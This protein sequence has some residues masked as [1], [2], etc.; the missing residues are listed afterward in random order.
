MNGVIGFGRELLDTALA[1]EQREMMC[2][3][4]GSAEELLVLLNDI[5]DFSRLEASKLR[6]EAVPT[7]L[8]RLVED[9][10]KLVEPETRKL[11]LELRVLCDP[12]IPDSVLSDRHR[13]RQVLCNLLTNAVKF[14][15]EGSVTLALRLAATTEHPNRLRFEVTDTGMGVPA[16]RRDLLF[17]PFR[18][19]DG[20]HARKFGGS[21]LG[22]S[23]CTRLVELMG[24]KIEVQSEVGSGSEFWFELDLPATT[25]KPERASWEVDVPG[26][27]PAPLVSAQAPASPAAAPATSQSP[28]PS[29]SPTRGMRI[30]LAEDNLTN[31]KLIKHVLSKLGSEVTVADDGNQVVDAFL[32]NPGGWDLILMDCQMPEKDGFQATAEIRSREASGPRTPIIALT[33]NAMVGDRERC[34]AAGM[35]DYL[36]K[37]LLTEEL[38][39]VLARWS[40]PPS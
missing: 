4:V 33:A 20:S 39:A 36:T 32:G 21:G 35:D 15:R 14:T 1:P 10:A 5:L 9:V 16:E 27:T 34:L 11:N 3:V 19:V 23:I 13:I 7:N 18:Q 30:L 12:R 40:N 8:R 26:P 28:T 38:R 22:L 17:E 6:L 29:R 24:G 37:P 25:V 2:T 31:Q